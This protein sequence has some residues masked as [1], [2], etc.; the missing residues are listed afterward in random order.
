MPFETPARPARRIAVVGAGISGMGAAWLLSRADQV[1][2]F[3]A[4]PRLGGHA[5]TVMAGRDGQTA[6]DT[7]FIVF[8]YQNY[9]RMTGMFEELGVPVSKS[10]MSFGATINDGAIEYALNSYDAIFAQRRNLLR[11][12][13]LGM[14]RDI[15]KFHRHAV[16]ASQDPN[17]TLGAFMDAL[18]LGQWFREYY[19]LPFSGAIWST[20]LDRISEF[21][22]RSL[23]RFFEN[24]ALLSANNQHQWYTVEGGSVQYVARLEAA[25]RANGAEIRL[26]SPV[27]GVRRPE[28]GGVELR[29]SGGEWEAFDHVVFASHSDETLAMLS[30]ASPQESAALGAIRY[31][32]NEAWLHCDPATMP[33][34]RKCWAS[35]VYKGDHRKPLPDRI[36]VSYWMNSLQP[37]LPKDDLLIVTLNPDAPVREDRVYDQTSFMHPVYDHA[38]LSAQEALRG[39]QGTRNTWFCG[40]YMKNGFHEDGYSSAVEVAEALGAQE[41]WA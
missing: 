31:Q 5:R 18:R 29:T 6:V 9:P 8:N 24:H 39:L 3:E 41:A 22:A 23:I 19:L 21:P 30:D 25:I 17:L 32:P 15:M 12:A 20:P 38:T 36:G 40:A 7:G 26:S 4:A 14:L 34:R 13:Y 28:G 27:S 35:W 37:F 16:P 10:T 33:R 11:P 1:V 2:L